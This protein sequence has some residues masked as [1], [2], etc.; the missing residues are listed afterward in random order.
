MFTKKQLSIID[1]VS[2]NDVIFTE[3]LER[4]IMDRSNRYKIMN[5]LTEKGILEKHVINSRRSVW[6]FSELGKAVA[7]Q[8]DP[9]YF[10]YFKIDDLDL[11]TLN[12][13]SKLI[14][15]QLSLQSLEDPI[16]AFKNE[17]YITRYFE[18]NKTDIKQRAQGT[19]MRIPDMA[20]DDTDHNPCCLELELS[21]KS[22]ARYRHIYNFY[23]YFKDYNYVFW[24]YQ[25]NHVCD[26]IMTYFSDFY[27]NDLNDY[28]LTNPDHVETLKTVK[29][30]HLFFHY[31][32]FIKD[33][34]K[35]DCIPFSQ[36]EAVEIVAI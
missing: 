33:G 17:K 15:I 32:D 16:Y 29:E 12:H 19:T 10:S 35:A 34:M 8:N 11:T 3:N 18:S 31:D 25:D 6:Y 20:F 21:Q 1:I 36:S 30:R 26:T 27:I 14:D 2:E 24:V 5:R 23:R 22:K 13:T 7:K 9:S 4:L 28:D